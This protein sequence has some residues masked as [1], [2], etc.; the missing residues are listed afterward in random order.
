MRRRPPNRIPRIRP[1]PPPPHPPPPRPPPPPAATPPPNPAGTR[2]SAYG[3][4]V[5]PAIEL[6][7]TYGEN[8]HSAIFAL[9]RTIAPASRSRF[10]I[11]ASVA[12]TVPFIASDPPV[13]C[14]PLV[15]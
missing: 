7:V 15:S 2:S 4:R 13:V 14:N 12:G 10:T 5:I 11:K 9:P 6:S 3:F 1:Q 8:A